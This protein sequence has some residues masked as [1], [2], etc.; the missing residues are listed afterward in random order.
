VF[1]GI[2]GKFQTLMQT[3]LRGRWKKVIKGVPRGLILSSLFLLTSTYFNDVHKITDN[4]AKAVLFADDTR[5]MVT[6]YNQE[7]VQTL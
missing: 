6:T 7:E 3:Y 2:S 1:N 4:D 5:V